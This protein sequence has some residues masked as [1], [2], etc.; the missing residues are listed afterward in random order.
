MDYKIV[1]IIGE[2]GDKHLYR[3][4]V[5]V[6]DSTCHNSVQETLFFSVTAEALEK[7]N[8]YSFL[9]FFFFFLHYL[10][11]LRFAFRTE[12]EFADYSHWKDRTVKEGF[13]L[14]LH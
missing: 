4:K 7:A 9:E 1:F 2:D 13:V 12:A 5:T 3:R 14:N 8:C 6:T 10:G 11:G